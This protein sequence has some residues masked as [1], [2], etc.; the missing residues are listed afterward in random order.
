MKINFDIFEA[1]TLFPEEFT[2]YADNR[3]TMN[4]RLVPTYD[5]KIKKVA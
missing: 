3:D 1:C 5:F 2:L 4:R